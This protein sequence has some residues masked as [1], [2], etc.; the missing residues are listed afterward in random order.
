MSIPAFYIAA[1]SQ[2]A[3]GGIYGFDTG[4]NM[5]SFAPLHVLI[6]KRVRVLPAIG[7]VRAYRRFDFRVK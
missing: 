3:N 4:L 7:P 1:R 5:V 2:E 6:R